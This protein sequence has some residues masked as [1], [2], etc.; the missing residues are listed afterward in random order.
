MD[1]K[2]RKNEA[3]KCPFRIFADQA[4]YLPGAEKRAVIP[5][6]CDSF[7]LADVQGNIVFEGKTTDCGFD[8]APELSLRTFPIL[9]G[10]D[11]TGSEQAAR[12]P[13]NLP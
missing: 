3:R 2:I 7:E 8:S 10:A 1:Y 11:V 9:P 6:E 5:F 13:L 12:P 4:G